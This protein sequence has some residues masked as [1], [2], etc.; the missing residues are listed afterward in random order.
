MR[1]AI[2]VRLPWLIVFRSKEMA[3]DGREEHEKSVAALSRSPDEFE[4]VE[5][6]PRVEVR[7]RVPLGLTLVAR[8]RVTARV[9]ARQVR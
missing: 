1:F 4:H 3:P 5:S 9:E 7:D 8:W 6:C 2:T